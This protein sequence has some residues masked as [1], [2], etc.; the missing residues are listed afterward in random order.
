MFKCN[1]SQRQS[2]EE[3]SE[4]TYTKQGTEEIIRTLRKN[5]TPGQ[6]K[7]T[8]SRNTTPLIS[9][10]FISRCCLSYRCVIRS[11]LVT[12]SDIVQLV[13]RYN[14]LNIFETYAD[15]MTNDAYDTLGVCRKYG[16]TNKTARR[17]IEKHDAHG[18]AHN[19]TIKKTSTRPRQ[20]HRISKNNT[21]KFK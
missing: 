21:V 17:I 20:Q 19:T 14:V 12:C 15:A 7:N 10:M 18:K 4:N 11:C 16:N 6:A 9:I 13:C 8:Q 1:G 3:Q 2:R 5:R